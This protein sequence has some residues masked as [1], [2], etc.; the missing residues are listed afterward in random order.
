[1][2][3]AVV[4]PAAEAGLEL[5]L[6][7]AQLVTWEAWREAHP[8]TEVLSFETGHWRE[9]DA[10]PYES[11]F[12]SGRLM[13]PVSYG[14][15]SDAG[16]LEEKE[17]VIVVESGGMLK[18]YPVSRLAAALDGEEVRDEFGGR[19]F[20]FRPV[21]AE[22]GTWFVTDEGG[23]AVPTAFS[24]WFKFRAAHPDAAVYRQGE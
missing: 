15:G 19:T 8:G 17:P 4:G 14:E 13:F 11:Y 3:K 1:M 24:F 2:L 22:G 16:A 20:V 10:N 12:E 9:Y 18:G 6:V 23:R 5:K 21:D 7:P